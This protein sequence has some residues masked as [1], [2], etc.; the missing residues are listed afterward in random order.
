MFSRQ[1]GTLPFFCGQKGVSNSCRTADGQQNGEH[2]QDG[3]DQPDGYTPAP[4]GVHPPLMES[5][6]AF[7]LGFAVCLVISIWIIQTPVNKSPIN[8]STPDTPKQAPPPEPKKLL[9]L[10]DFPRPHLTKEIEEI[11]YRDQFKVT[12]QRCEGEL[13]VTCLVSVEPGDAHYLGEMWT[14]CPPNEPCISLVTSDQLDAYKADFGAC[15][16]DE[17]PNVPENF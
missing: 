3:E 17:V 13:C 8:R 15:E 16:R 10:H 4:L 1:A 9:R 6:S 7:G 5:S 12:R 2:D 14:N 11:A